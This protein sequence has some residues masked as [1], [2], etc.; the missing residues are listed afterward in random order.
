MNKFEKLIEY[1]IN[2]ETAKAE[3]LF[4]DIVVEKSRGI[5][6]GLMDMEEMGGDAADSYQSD[7][8]ADEIGEGE[9]DM[10]MSAEPEMGDEYADDEMSMDGD[11]SDENIEDRVVDL[12]DKL[13]DLMA[14]FNEIIGGDEMSAEPEMAMGDEYADDEM[15]MEPEMEPQY[16]SADEECDDD[17]E[18]VTEEDEID[19]ANEL[20]ENVSLT[21]VTKGISNSSEAEGTNKTSVN[22]NNSGAKNSSAKPVTTGT[23]PA[24]GQPTPS[25]TAGTSTT[26][27]NESKVKEP[28]KKGEEGATNKKS[29]IEG[30]QRKTRK[31]KV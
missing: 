19:E 27:P 28:K 2:D 14:E 12:E 22:A 13:D 10:E 20:D 1:V 24:N 30:K 15:S 8:S 5:Y 25:Y 31:R 11:V 16:E 26:E 6:E 7:I 18:E 4:H 29:V 3:E 21:K 9:D 17:A 23:K